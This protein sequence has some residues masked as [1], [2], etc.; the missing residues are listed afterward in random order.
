MMKRLG[1]A[2][3]VLLNAMSIAA[4]R[5]VPVSK[6]IQGRTAVPFS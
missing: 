3:F 4:D 6:E 2:A 5:G 1:A